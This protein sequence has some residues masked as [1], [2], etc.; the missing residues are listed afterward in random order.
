M[1]SKKNTRKSSVKKASKTTIRKFDE[2]PNEPSSPT[3]QRISSFNPFSLTGTERPMDE[4][5]KPRPKCTFPTLGRIARIIEIILLLGFITVIVFVL[6]G[7]A[8][9]YHI[10][11]D[12]SDPNPG[13]GT[14]ICNLI[15]DSLFNKP[16]HMFDLPNKMNYFANYQFTI[17]DYAINGQVIN[18]IIETLPPAIYNPTPDVVL[19]FWDSDIS[20]YDEY[21]MTVEQI[22]HKRMYYAQNLTYV[23]NTTLEAGVKYMAVGGPGFLGEGYLLKKHYY[24]HKIDQLND[25]RIINEEVTR[26]MNVTYVNVRHKY[27]MG[28]PWYW[29]YFMWYITIDGE[30]ENARGTR[31]VSELFGKELQT[32]LRGYNASMLG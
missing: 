26:N 31:F 12:T 20:N 30:H 21:T 7:F 29:P 2:P 22:Y 10:V 1:D 19:L 6:I 23:I 18:N 28:L 32:W 8:N 25:Y 14:L 16:F 13:N 3:F 5:K 4:I 24:W 9:I 11:E 15:G 27:L 17:N